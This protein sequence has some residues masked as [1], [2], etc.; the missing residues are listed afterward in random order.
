MKYDIGQYVMYRNNGVCRVEAI[1]KLRFLRNNNGTYYTLRPPFATN[2]ERSYIPT[3]AEEYLRSVMK[4][5][6]IWTSC[7]KWMSGHT[8]QGNGSSLFSI[9]RS[10]FLP[11][12]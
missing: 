8:I 1:G 12:I 3:T 2:D 7:L 4:P 10:C 5:M 9:I 6:C 11:M